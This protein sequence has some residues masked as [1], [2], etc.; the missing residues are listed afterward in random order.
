MYVTFEDG[1][2]EAVADAVRA[3]SADPSVEGLLLLLAADGRVEVEGVG[4]VVDAASVPVVGGVFPELIHAGRRRDHGAVVVGLPDEPTVTTVT[5]PTDGSVRS[6]LHPGALDAGH[7]TGFA[8][9]DA[10]ADW[11]DAFVKGLFDTYGVELDLVGGGAG[12]LDGPSGPT[13][14]TGDGPVTDGAAVATVPTAADVGVRHGWREVDGPFR[15]TE[16]DGR[17]LVALDGEPAFE[18]YRAA[19]EADDGG[20]VEREAFF[21][22]AKAYPLGISRMGDETIVRDPFEVDA[23]GAMDCF[24]AVPEGEFLHV[25]WGD[26]DRLV[27]AAAEADSAVGPAAATR[28]CFDCI[29]R[30]LYLEGEFERELDAIG[31]PA[32]PAAGALT[33]GE[34]ANDGRGHLDF[35]NKTAVVAGFEE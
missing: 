9:I 29:S 2:R 31:G 14:F 17:T 34:I 5:T 16:A 3:A 10:Y 21:E 23:A 30:V 8:L 6:Q 1:D 7:R 35:Y 22:T 26:P 32:E 4:P 24:G 12:S 15:V 25:L 27:A 18:R 33:I 13:V 11:V 28:L 20:P 19:V